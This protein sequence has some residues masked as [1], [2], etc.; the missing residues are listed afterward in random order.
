[1]KKI[2]LIAVFLL[3]A[4]TYAQ[5]VPPTFSWSNKSDYLIDGEY[6]FK[7]GDVINYTIDYTLGSTDG[8]ADTKWFALFSFQSKAYDAAADA[9]TGNDWVTVDGAGPSYADPSGSITIPALQDLSSAETKSYR[10]LVYLA[11]YKGGDTSM[12]V[13]GGAG[14]SDNQLISI[15]SQA[16]VDLL[17]IEDFENSPSIGAY[18]NPTNGVV[19][20]GQESEVYAV[21]DVTGRLVSSQKG[22]KSIDLTTLQSGIN[23]V[24]TDFGIIQVIKN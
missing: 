18:P 12:Q 23:S 6:V 1:M 10:I 17:S 9:A 19:N 14:A 24:K 4:I 5:I 21:F 8:V 22:G 15:K 11:Y 13:F 16:E 3:S 20:F 2:T 7:P